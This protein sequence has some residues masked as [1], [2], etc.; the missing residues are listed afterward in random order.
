MRIRA[1]P[2]TQNERRTNKKLPAA[3][4]EQSKTTEP[5]LPDYGGQVN[6]KQS[7]LPA[8]QKTLG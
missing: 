7:L 2:M 6:E 4:R 3:S 1:P 8:D 5:I